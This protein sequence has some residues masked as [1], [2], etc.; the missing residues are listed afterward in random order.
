MRTYTQALELHGI[1]VPE[2]LDHQTQVPIL[3]TLQRQ[4][5]L[6][7]VPVDSDL[8]EGDIVPTAGVQL[9]VGEGTGNTHWLDGLGAVSFH[10]IEDDLPRVGVITVPE[11]AVGYVTHT[12]EHGSNAMGEGRYMVVRAREQAERIRVVSD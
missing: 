9:V 11:G 5:D 3:T 6:L 7:I 4:G 12:D 8:P 1:T 10:R 2:H